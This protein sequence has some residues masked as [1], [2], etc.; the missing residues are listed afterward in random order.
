MK[1]GVPKFYSMCNTKCAANNDSWPLFRLS[2]SLFLTG[3]GN[4]TNTTVRQNN[5]SVGMG[6]G[7]RSFNWPYRRRHHKVLRHK[8]QKPHVSLS[9]TT[10]SISLFT[11]HAIA[12]SFQT[13]ASYSSSPP[14]STLYPSTHSILLLSVEIPTNF[15]PSPEWHV[16]NLL[17]LTN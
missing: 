5:K 2:L 10:K 14:P 1:R 7:R 8:F 6:V 17:D 12:I 9:K 13:S 3:N 4:I 11:F 16:H 15:D